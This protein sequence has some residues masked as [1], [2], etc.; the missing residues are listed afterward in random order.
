MHGACASFPRTQEEEGEDAD[1]D[2]DPEWEA[3][4]AL[5]P[6]E[7]EGMEA[8][9][10]LLHQI[11]S[12]GYHYNDV[13]LQVRAVNQIIRCPTISPENTMTVLREAIFTTGDMGG[14]DDNVRIYGSAVGAGGDRLTELP[15][16]Y[17]LLQEIRNGS[18]RGSDLSL[19]LRLVQLLARHGARLEHKG[20]QGESALSVLPLLGDERASQ[21]E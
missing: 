8:A 7:V 5:V 6:V 4:Y 16:L 1:L 2:L 21:G 12:G 19:Q 14:E 9:R 13:R 17:V 10:K 11:G 3:L 18:L 15:P 20:P